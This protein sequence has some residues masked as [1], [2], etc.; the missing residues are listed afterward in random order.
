MFPLLV[1]WG[2]MVNKALLKQVLQAA[3]LE[4][5]KERKSNEKLVKK[6]VLGMPGSRER[7]DLSDYLVHFAKGPQ[8]YWTMLEILGGQELLAGETAV[9]CSRDQKKFDQERNRAICFSETPLGYLDKFAKRRSQY[10]IGFSKKF[11]LKNQGMPIWYVPTGTNA[12]RAIHNLLAMAK[13]PD[14]DDLRR[15]LI[16]DDH[17]IWSLCPFIEETRDFGRVQHQYQWER[18]WRVNATKLKF[19]PSDVAFLIIPERLHVNARAFF[20]NAKNEN[21]GP[22]YLGC[23]YIDATW[24]LDKYRN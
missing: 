6:L 22:A 16:D 23:P 11:I 19:K 3:Y 13:H 8:A 21:T 4:A 5:E 2:S 10:G 9:G 17:P 24:N 12:Y 1:L 7:F 20:V 18:E 14:P 15:K